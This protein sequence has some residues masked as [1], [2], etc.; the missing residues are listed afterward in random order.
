MTGTFLG[1]S[2]LPLE[3]ILIER[4]KI[5]QNKNPD[6]DMGDFVILKNGP[7]A[8]KVASH[9][10]IIDRHTGEI[11]HHAVSIE[12]YRRYKAGW[13]WDEQHS[14][15]LEDKDDKETQKL[16]TF[17][18]VV[19]ESSLS[20][21]AGHYLV[22]PVKNRSVNSGALKQLYEAI[23]NDSK[24][25]LV[26]Q[27]LSIAKGDPEVL[28]TLMEK[29]SFDMEASKATAAALNSV[30]FKAA[31]QELR[32]CIQSDSREGKYQSLLAKNP[33]M[34]G[35]EYSELLNQRVWTR[36]QEQDFMMRCTTDGYL[37]VIEIKTTLSGRSLFI[38]DPSHDSLY[39]RSEL[40]AVLGQDMAYLED[41]DTN[42][43]VVKMKDTED[44]N[45]I[46]A[47]III[48][49]TGDSEQ[50]E[51]LRRLNGHLH[52]IEVLTFDQ[53]ER[54]ASQVVSYLDGELTSTIRDTGDRN[55]SDFSARPRN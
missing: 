19:L 3:A 42:R 9:W 7:L 4:K 31:L 40:S 46:R 35:S 44:V 1:H 52:R 18:D 15:T 13:S 47:K 23:T 21:N 50:Q 53:L 48:G 22:V 38:K 43:S 14:I 34:F 8:F 39:P 11:H 27:A 41:L 26:A 25:D 17:L 28:H 36:N 45:K 24:A 20:S 49:R 16:S 5:E 32:E 10:V 6:V 12:T 54:I 29:A 37:E 55:E 51:A 30:R 2:D 33:W